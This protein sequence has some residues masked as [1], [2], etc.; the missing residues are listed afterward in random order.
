MELVDLRSPGAE[1]VRS[2]ARLACAEQQIPE[3]Q[4]D[5]EGRVWSALGSDALLSALDT[6]ARTLSE[7]YLVVHD[8]D[9]FL[10]GYIDLLVDGGPGALAILDYKTDRATTDAEIAAK[11]EHYAPQLAAYARAVE[12]VTGAAPS[13]TGLIFAR[14]GGRP[15]ESPVSPVK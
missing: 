6:D 1:E 15:K 12:Q 8:A 11:Q 13:S 9:R 3:L 2:L 4:A 5:I 14:P 7:V 10:E